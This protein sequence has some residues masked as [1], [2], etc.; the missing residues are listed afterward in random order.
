MTFPSI[1]SVICAESTIQKQVHFASWRLQWYHRRCKKHIMYLSQINHWTHY[2]KKPFGHFIEKD[3]G[4]DIITSLYM[5]YEI[6][7]YTYIYIFI[8]LYMYVYIYLYIYI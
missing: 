7:I 4:L 1:F 6:Y 3:W 8:Y 5:K 2:R